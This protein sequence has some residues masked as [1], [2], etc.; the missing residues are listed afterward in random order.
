[1]QHLTTLSQRI[2]DASVDCR[3]FTLVEL[4]MVIGIIVA[5]FSV[6]L[7]LLGLAQR[8]ADKGATKVVMAKV[9]TAIRLFRSEIGS[10]PWQPTYADLA[11][12]ATWDN[13]LYWHVGTDI[14]TADLDTLRS[15]AVAAALVYRM[16]S[17]PVDARAFKE[18]DGAGYAW[19]LNTMA[20]ERARLAIFAGN[21]T[22]ATPVVDPAYMA[23]WPLVYRRVIPTTPLLSAP[24]SRGW[25]RDFLVGEIPRKHRSGDAILDGWGR[26][27]L[28][29]GQVVEGMVASPSDG[30]WTAVIRPRDYGMQ[31]QGRTTLA[32]VDALTAKPLTV[33]AVRLPDLANLRRSDRRFY[34]PRGLELEFELWSAGPDRRADWMRDAAVNRDN[35]PLYNYD[36]SLP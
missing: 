27:L 12:G 32:P 23:T 35:V 19:M 15:E 31:A 2:D 5:L 11:S 10:Y 22:V 34:A 29:V 4:I 18:T 28:Y 7:P 13:R 36:G 14:S 1:M 3:A 25:A 16:D 8:E 26:P 6:S 17:V 9:D 33:D 24:T 21:T 20:S 30:V